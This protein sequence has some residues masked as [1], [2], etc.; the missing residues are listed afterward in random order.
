MT[1]SY[2]RNG[3]C[4]HTVPGGEQCKGADC[5]DGKYKMSV[6]LG[7]GRTSINFMR[8]AH[9]GSPLA[10]EDRPRTADNWEDTGCVLEAHEDQA[11]EE[12]THDV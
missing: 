11:Q 9:V 4:L 5:V 10:V 2:I 7:S 8:N 1:I 6:H 3:V 12:C